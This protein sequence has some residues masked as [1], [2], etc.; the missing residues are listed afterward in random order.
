MRLDVRRLARLERRILQRRICGPEFL[1]RLD[2]GAVADLCGK[3]IAP[4]DL[5]EDRLRNAIW[6]SEADTRL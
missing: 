6:F 3:L 1:V 4:A 2:D 5:D